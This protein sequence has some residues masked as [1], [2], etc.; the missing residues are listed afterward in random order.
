MDFLPKSRKEGTYMQQL[1][2]SNQHQPQGQ[3]R[4]SPPSQP[5]SGTQFPPQQQQWGQQ[6]PQQP[7]TDYPHWLGLLWAFVALILCATIVFQFG[8]LYV[9]TASAATGDIGYQDGSTLGTGSSSATGSKPES[10]LW[11]TQDNVWW[12]WMWNGSRYDIARLDPTTH[13]WMLQGLN[14]SETRGD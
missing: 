9:R 12:S 14:I 11:F 10:K 1:P 3:W 5:L 8:P 13:S 6:P 4:Q 2:P 7:W